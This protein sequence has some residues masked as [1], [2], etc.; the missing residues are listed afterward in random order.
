M[1]SIY[2][3]FRPGGRQY[4]ELPTHT[5]AKFVPLQRFMGRDRG[6]NYPGSRTKYM[7]SLLRIGSVR[8]FPMSCV[9]TDKD[10]DG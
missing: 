3:I 10:I 6:V 9:N 5:T 2:Q 7:L 1:V 8:S 4:D